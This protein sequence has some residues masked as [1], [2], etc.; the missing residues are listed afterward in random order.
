M[1]DAERA[2]AIG[3][4]NRGVEPDELDAAALEWAKKLA[5]GPS[6]FAIGK[7][8]LNES[9]LMFLERQIELE[10]QGIVRAAGTADYREGLRAFFDKRPPV[11]PD[12]SRG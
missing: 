7:Q 8:L 6:S 3:L 9:M 10:R 11:F 2:L 5:S 12:S 4:V 1:I